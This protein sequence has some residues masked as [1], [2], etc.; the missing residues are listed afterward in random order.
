MPTPTRMRMHRRALRCLA[1]GDRL[2]KQDSGMEQ[3]GM[4]EHMVNHKALLIQPMPHPDRLLL[5]MRV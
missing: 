1:H 2:R 5:P 4:V 3:R